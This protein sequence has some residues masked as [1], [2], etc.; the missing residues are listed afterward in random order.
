MPLG[1]AGGGTTVY[2]GNQI[3]EIVSGRHCSRADVHESRP[4]CVPLAAA[5][6]GRSPIVALSHFCRWNTTP[7]QARLRASRHRCLPTA[8]KCTPQCPCQSS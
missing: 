5:L 2:F 7:W 1:F 6:I 8:R 3:C 4:C